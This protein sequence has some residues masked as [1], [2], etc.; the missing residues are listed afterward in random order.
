MTPS[1][2][3]GPIRLEGE[4]GPGSDVVVPRQLP[5]TVGHFVGRAAA[6]TML[7]ELLPRQAR[8]GS[9]VVISAISGTAGIGKTALAVHWAHKVAPHFPD[10]QLYVNLRGFDPSHEPM[11]PADAIRAVPG[12]ARR[13]RATHSGRSGRQGGALPVTAR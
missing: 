1:S 7:A 9:A 10:G 12:R 11:P 4:S 2:G 8:A 3:L 6:L 5:G 13:T